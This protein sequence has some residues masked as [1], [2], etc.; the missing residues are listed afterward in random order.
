MQ[1]P[2][3]LEEEVELTTNEQAII[4]AMLDPE[5]SIEVVVPDDIDPEKFWS[6]LAACCRAVTKMRR[7]VER[8]RPIIGRMLLVAQENPAIYEDKGYRTYEDFL[9]RGVCENL[10]LSRSDAYE[11]K[12][13]AQKWPSLTPEEYAQIGSVK[14]SLLSRVADER[15]G[16]GRKLLEKAKAL[17]I[18]DLRTELEK[19]ALIER[20]EFQ[21]AVIV[22]N[23]TRTI[24]DQFERFVSLP[25]VQAHCETSDRGAILGHMI[26]E[27]EVEWTAQSSR[28]D[29]EEDAA[30]FA[31][32][33]T[34]PPPPAIPQPPPLR[35]L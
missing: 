1:E 14:M 8:L 24:A 10:G 34:L 15:T 31:E 19:K 35:N 22:I 23:T 6:S 30:G 3:K 13:V 5:A 32:P 12:R 17:S 29:A 11:A 20:G 9:R 25:E 16:R 33:A 27:C 18:R 7:L 26:E 4:K 28:L 2:K 21:G